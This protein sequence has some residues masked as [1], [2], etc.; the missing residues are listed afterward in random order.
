MLASVGTSVKAMSLKELI[1]LVGSVCELFT[2]VTMNI[3]LPQLGP[4]PPLFIKSIFLIYVM[5][6]AKLVTLAS[7]L[8]RIAWSTT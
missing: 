1:S 4:I 3:L 8:S 6:V 2:M 5:F 7:M